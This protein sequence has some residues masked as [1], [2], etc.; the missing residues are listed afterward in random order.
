MC[1]HCYIFQTIFLFLLI[2]HCCINITV[3]PSLF[4]P[5][6]CDLMGKHQ[7]ILESSLETELHSGSSCFIIAGVHF[8]TGCLCVGFATLN[9]LKLPVDRYDNSSSSLIIYGMSAYGSSLLFFAVMLSSCSWKSRFINLFF[10]MFAFTNHLKDKMPRS[11]TTSQNFP[12]EYLF[13]AGDKQ[14]FLWK[15][16]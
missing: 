8:S 16:S 6:R 15:L 7:P 5:V 1:Y 11:I 4:S 12:A 2:I 9:C 10:S 13:Y 3:F 14:T